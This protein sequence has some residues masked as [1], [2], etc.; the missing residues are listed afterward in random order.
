MS[1]D[2]RTQQ[3]YDLIGSLASTGTESPTP[4]IG[5]VTTVNLK[6]HY[7]Y[8]GTTTKAI[9]T[10]GMPQGELF[11]IYTV[12]AGET[13]NS[14]QIQWASGPDNINFGPQ[15]NDSTSG[16]TSTLTQREFSI[17]QA[18]TYGLLAYGTQTGNFT[19]GLKITGGTSSATAYIES[20]SDAGSTGTLTLSNIT[21]TFQNAETITDSGTG[22]ATTTNV[23]QSVTAFSI[24]LDISSRYQRFSVKETGVASNVGKLYLGIT[25]SGR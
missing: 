9:K 11:G 23:L 1:L 13:A 2:Y 8:A 24:P 18:T 7:D 16:G 3:H 12:G 5:T 10:V 21:G 17:T 19:V 22:S 25:L 20:D 4:S 15:V 6:D 14:L